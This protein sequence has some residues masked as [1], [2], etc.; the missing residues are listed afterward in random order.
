[1][2]NDLCDVTVSKSA[3]SSRKRKRW[4]VITSVESLVGQKS[5]VSRIHNDIK[6]TRCD[7]RL[8][9]SQSAAAASCHNVMSLG[10]GHMVNPQHAEQNMRLGVQV[11]NHSSPNKRWRKQRVNDLVSKHTA[12]ETAHRS[13]SLQAEFSTL[14]SESAASSTTSQRFDLEHVSIQAAA[15]PTTTTT[16]TSTTPAPAPA[17]TARSNSETLPIAASRSRIVDMVRSNQ[18]VVITGDTGSGKSTQLGKYLHQAGFSSN[19]MIAVTQPRRIGAVSV[20][21]RVAEEMAV[22]LGQEVGYTIRFENVTSSQTKI[23]FITD[24]CLLRECLEHPELRPYSVIIL[25]EAHER[26]LQTD[27]LLAMVKRLALKRPDLK[28]I[29]TSA[30]LDTSK[31]CSYFFQ[32]PSMH[33][34]GR[35]YP[36]E[37]IHSRK[38]ETYY[39]EAAVE[40]ALQIHLKE[41]MGHILVFLTGR[42]EIDRAVKLM[43]SKLDSLFDDGIDMPDVAVLP[44]YGALA[45]NVQQRIFQQTGPNT[46]KIV[47]STNI[48]ETS[49]TVDGVVYVIDTGFSKQRNFDSQS[50]ID[51]LIVVDISKVA[52]VQR[53]GRAGRTRPGKCYRLYT[54]DHF[55]NKLAAEALP[56]IRRTNL[57]NTV[58]MLKN[59]GIMNPLKFDFLDNPA[60]DSSM[61][62]LKELYF[63]GAIDRH[64]LITPLGRCMSFFPI[65]PVLA[66]L[67]T[68]S[69]HYKCVEEMLTMTAMMSVENFWIRPPKSELQELALADRLRQAFTS[70]FGDH[71]TYLFVFDAWKA[72]K[73]SKSWAASKYIHFRALRRAK[74]VRSQLS[75]ILQDRAHE[76]QQIGTHLLRHHS[77]DEKFHIQDPIT[78]CRRCIAETLFPHAAMS[79]NG[80]GAYQPYS[81]KSHDYVYLHPSTALLQDP[82]KWV[83]FH[84]I[85]YTSKPYLRNFTVIDF[86]WI[87]KRL[88]K[89]KSV[90]SAQL[91]GRDAAVGLDLPGP[92]DNGD[93]HHGTSAKQCPA[94]AIITGSD[95]LAADSQ[96][97]SASS[98]AGPNTHANAAASSSREAARQR[99]LARR[100]L[101]KT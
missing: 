20:A 64:G 55:E 62:A 25:D 70:A 61:D 46:R 2:S 39:V 26:S 90:H 4:D 32:C 77:S 18:I 99:Y 44:I 40:T 87:K 81:G 56:E 60:H 37:V 28:I 23:R 6:T 57:A 97:S 36:V 78:M 79:A 74:E 65:E 27:I 68:C 24:G 75:R 17:A 7:P 66:R 59:V 9:V 29:V 47:F 13:L 76:V 84:E 63:L 34:P 88:H 42:D 69:V 52:A 98:S 67:L 31:F 8:T 30:T 100:K 11:E 41:P 93:E 48:C 71:V 101:N 85:M 43:E 49:I 94:S 10:S 73:F 21:K 15:I 38:Q 35:C 16:T 5:S 83:V 89:L 54:R 12:S 86:A 45:S 19:G 82:P 50:G 51:S 95:P 33:I 80:R 22:P 72:N 14:A 91:C 53:A 58:L 3:I 1:M 92:N 96:S